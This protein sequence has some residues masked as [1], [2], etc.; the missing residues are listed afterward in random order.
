MNLNLGFLTAHLRLDTSH[1]VAG[2]NTFQQ[3]LNKTSQ[4][5]TQFGAYMSAAVT[6][7]LTLFGRKALKEF[8]EFDKAITRSMA[9]MG[10]ASDQLRSQLSSVAVTLSTKVATPARE[11]AKGYF[12]LGQAGYT[13]EQ[14]IAA[15]PITESFAYAGSMH[16]SQAVSYLTKS[17]RSLGME[18]TDP[19]ENLRQMT[20]V[21]DN[22]T[23]AAI[24]S[25]AEIIDF[26][27]A[28]KNA[29]PALRILN[30]DIEEGTAA[31]M[32]LAN[33]GHV[34][35]EAGTQLYMVYRDLQ[36]ANITQRAVW[37]KLK[38]SVYDTGGEM[39]NIADIIQDL[40]MRFTGMSDEGVRTT[41][42]MLGF[43]DRSLR[44]TQAL[45]G[46][47]STIRK[48][49]ELLK[50]AGGLTKKVQEDYLRSFAAQL[51]IL[52]N[53]LSIVTRGIGEIL[54]QRLM[55]LS[56]AVTY[57]VRA[58]NMMSESMQNSVVNFGIFAA[59]LGPV[60]LGFA[61]LI[62]VLSYTIGL[63]LKLGAA[64][65]TPFAGVLAFIALAYTVRAVWKQ[66]LEGL[67][68][69]I[70]DF[71][72]I[73]TDGYNWL[74]E[75][76]GGFLDDYVRGWREAFLQLREDWKETITYMAI[77]GAGLSE[78]FKAFWNKSADVP[79]SIEGFRKAWQAGKDAFDAQ[80]LSD[81]ESIEPMKE[82]VGNY[83]GTVRE[84]APFY[85]KAGKQVGEEIFGAVRQQLRDDF[86]SLLPFFQNNFPGLVSSIQNL[87][88]G[89]E[90]PEFDIPKTPDFKAQ[91]QSVREE[92]ARIQ[93]DLQKAKEME[94]WVIGN[95]EYERRRLEINAQIY[96]EL[97]REN[98]AYE[99]Q[100]K[101]LKSQSL[102][103]ELNGG[104]IQLINKW[105]ERQNE[106]LSISVNKYGSIG[107]QL[108]AAYRQMKIEQEQAAGPWYEF[109]TTL[110][111]MM[112]NGFM[113]MAKAGRDWGDQMKAMLEEIY[114]EFV[115]LQFIKPIASALS[116]GF[117]FGMSSLF[118]GNP[119]GTPGPSPVGT[120]TSGVFDYQLGGMASGG[121]AWNPQVKWV[122]EKEPELITP[123][124]Q[125]GN[126]LG[127][128]GNVSVNVINESGVPLT[129]SKEEQYIMSDQ[130]II[131]VVVRRAPQDY[132]LQKALGVRR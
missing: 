91:L 28:M 114:W 53:K 41:L 44:A 34:G 98:G 106:L 90:S 100:W 73:F 89:F 4:K 32:A 83:L 126:V 107:D 50:E 69:D 24:E 55:S 121:I 46:L 20:R 25:T 21:A 68:Q 56:D 17:L 125:V 94:D 130:R 35:S 38:L 118:G 58:W 88:S 70:Q 119:S 7:P 97:I 22:L 27:E 37:E 2:M 6:L 128:G 52:S 84:M 78:G 102:Q 85:V 63:W 18:S 62:K 54:A 26:S 74:N 104:D 103:L 14:S 1:Y 113:N 65:L 101:Y 105:L 39:K 19:E 92:L 10:G 132:Q 29:G 80:A 33:Q 48:Y 86:A 15:L 30:K 124:S 9:V 117:S 110:P 111:Q 23:F 16:L 8:L 51:D 59:L 82:V 75:K 42:M 116:Q 81:L 76:T 66:G 3:Q 5:L 95:T 36:R 77:A 99:A 43:Q 122:A 115:R 31:L 47:S 12:E 13:A 11:L 131:D 71:F 72:S 45:F 64:V 120:D 129:V 123:L 93:V 49:E 79:F 67:S 60:T 61:G 57:V 87:M 127:N 112:E 108:D 109:A 40:E 96:S